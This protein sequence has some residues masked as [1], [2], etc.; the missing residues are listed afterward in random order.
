MVIFRNAV[1]EYFAAFFFQI[2]SKNLK[3]FFYVYRIIIVKVC[4]STFT[5]KLVL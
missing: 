2:F 5:I 3:D 1:K 4:E